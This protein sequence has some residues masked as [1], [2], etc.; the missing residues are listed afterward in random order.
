MLEEVWKA[1]ED[2]D[3]H[4]RSGEYLNLLLILEMSLKQP[5][6]RFEH[7]LEFGGY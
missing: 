4:L 5:E 3:F 1:E 6:I 2:L 7:H